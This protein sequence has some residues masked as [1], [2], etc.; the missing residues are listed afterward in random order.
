MI[1]LR[2]IGPDVKAIYEMPDS[3]EPVAML[4]DTPADLLNGARMFLGGKPLP[5]DWRAV[6]GNLW[7]QQSKT[8]EAERKK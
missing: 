1:R 3:T 5:A 4:H 7:A 8:I 6:D 2:V